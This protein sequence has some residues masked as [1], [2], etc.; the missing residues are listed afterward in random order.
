MIN[1]PQPKRTLY[2]VM[3]GNAPGVDLAQARQAWPQWQAYIQSLLDEGRFVLA[4][5]FQG[6]LT[7][8]TVFSAA[9]QEEAEAIVAR[10]PMV[11]AGFWRAG[12]VLPWNVL[13]GSDV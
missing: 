11:A 10:D 9:S 1:Q 7:G 13:A 6:T 4:G 12:K 2:A 5:G 3:S 8:M